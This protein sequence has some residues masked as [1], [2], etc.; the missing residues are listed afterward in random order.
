MSSGAVSLA[1]ASISAVERTSSLSDRKLRK[2]A[3][4]PAST[5]VAMTCAPW[6]MN[7]SAMARPMPWPAAV[8]RAS[9]PCSRAVT[10]TSAA[11]VG[12]QC[13]Q[14]FIG[15]LFAPGR[16]RL[17]LAVEDDVAETLEVILRKL[18]QIGRHRAGRHHVA[19]VTGHAEFAVDLAALIDLRLAR[20]GRE[21]RLAE[22]ESDRRSENRPA[23]HQT[24][25]S[26]SAA[27]WIGGVP[28][29]SPHPAPFRGALP[30]SR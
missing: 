30:S 25:F 19:P 17:P 12:P 8:M 13:G 18:A 26:R 11:H 1:S 24:F 3:S 21:R 14:I 16:H 15:D 7:A 27:I 2:S 10:L 5:S 4:L 20:L 22:R 28:G 6:A 29:F 23:R 9:L